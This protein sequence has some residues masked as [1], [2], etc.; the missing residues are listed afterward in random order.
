MNSDYSNFSI[1]SV[2]LLAAVGLV[3]LLLLGSA[4]CV[5]SGHVGVVSLMGSISD[6][7]EDPGFHFVNPICN[8]IMVSTQARND[9]VAYTAEDELAAVTVDTQTV[10]FQLDIG[11][12][13]NAVAAPLLVSNFGTDPTV[14]DEKIV[15]PCM[16][17]SAKNILS[18]RPLSGENSIISERPAVASEISAELSKLV[19]ARL[20]AKNPLLSG[21][22]TILQVN[23]SNIT[24]SASY[25]RVIQEK[26]EEQERILT[27]ENTLARIRIEAQQQVAQ[28]ESARE[29]A[30]ARAEGTARSAVI[31]AEGA[32]TA[33]VTRANAESEAI[34][35]VQRAR[36]EGFL[37]MVQAGVNPTDFMYYETWNGELPRLF[38]GGGGMDLV[39]PAGTPLEEITEENLMLILEHMDG[40]IAG[41]NR[42]VDGFNVEPNTTTVPSEE[43]STTTVTPED[44]QTVPTEGE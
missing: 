2:V 40:Q 30:I 11:W 16:L 6:E 39:V 18:Q 26:Q 44:S 3:V 41:M 37:W 22:I 28:A 19:E 29:A 21:A 17:Q 43:N 9:T 25:E 14:W 7:T 1:S 4:T 12:N 38:A 15:I 23:L 34:L 36:V 32:A 42:A 24:Y 10:G 20:I 27:A 8:V 5:S 13:V 31:N 33:A 35:L